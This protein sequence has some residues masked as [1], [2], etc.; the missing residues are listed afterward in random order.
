MKL[1]NV[2]ILSLSDRDRVRISPNRPMPQ[3]TNELPNHSRAATTAA[4]FI[5]FAI[6]LSAPAISL[7]T[8]QDSSLAFRRTQTLRHGINLSH[9]FAQAG[10]PKNY[11]KEHFDSY[12]T[13]QDMALIKAMGFDHVRFTLNCDPMFRRG[14]A[15]R[16]PPEYLAMVDAAV[17]MILDHRLAIII[18]IHPESDFKQKLV[19]DDSCFLRF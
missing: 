19:A 13:A 17:K 15:D 16:I 1:K 4:R 12:D 6:F 11:T 3:P 18:D 2:V 9:W 5:L 14:Q 10:D 8:A 7:A